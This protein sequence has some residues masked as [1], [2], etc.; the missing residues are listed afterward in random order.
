MN[1][2]QNLAGDKVNTDNAN[3]NAAHGK[4]R[5]RVVVADINSGNV[6]SVC[7]ALQRAGADAVLS[8]DRDD[9]S[10]ADGLLLPGVG[11][12]S[13]VM[14]ALQERDL[15]RLIDQRLAGGRPV[16]GICVGLQVMFEKG[17][18]HGVDCAG[19]G[20]WPG[21][22]MALP[23]K[24]LPHM[25]WASV[26]PPADSALFAG[27]ENERFYFVH[28]YAVQTDPAVDLAPVGALRAPLVT[29]AHHGADFV[30]AVENGP[31]CAT[32]FHPE[33]SG[34]AGQRLLQNWLRTL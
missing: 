3:T 26:H 12:F 17:V 10:H 33:K 22:V 30:A 1:G 23:A 6:R 14:A 19:L 24:R 9:I 18:E 11:A 16:L 4:A 27:V 20:Q 34:P 5:P 15:P 2:Q 7:R 28:S 31:L 8:A 25:G 29:W 21:Q 13:Q 32:Q